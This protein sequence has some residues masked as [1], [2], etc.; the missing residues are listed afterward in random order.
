MGSQKDKQGNDQL[1]IKN[2]KRTKIVQKTKR[3]GSTWALQTLLEE[4]EKTRSAR[5]GR[6]NISD[7]N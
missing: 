6:L 3:G 2:V 5:D 1:K 7:E 4:N